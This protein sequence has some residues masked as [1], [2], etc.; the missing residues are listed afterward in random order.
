LIVLD[1]PCFKS[2][3]AF[4]EQDARDELGKVLAS[5]TFQPAQLQRRFLAFAVEELL[6]GRAHLLK[7][8]VIATEA[9][10][11][12]AS[13]DPR[14]D[15]I[16]RTEARKLRARLAKYYQTEGSREAFCIDLPK[17]SYVP[18][19]RGMAEKPAEPLP[20]ES[21][22][23]PP[24]E[25]LA[26][27]VPA[28]QGAAARRPLPWKFAYGLLAIFVLAAAGAVT[29][30]RVSSQTAPGTAATSDDASIAVLPLVNLSDGSEEFLSEGLTDEIIN[31]LTQIPGLRVVART[32]SFRFRA[33]AAGTKDIDRKLHVRA[34]LVG[35][36]R[37]SDRRLR[38]ALEL[39]DAANGYHLWSGNYETD[40]VGVGKLPLEIANAVTNA[41]GMASA[42]GE[43]GSPQTSALP[44]S[45]AQEDYLRGL[46]FQNK[47]TV[48]SLKQATEYYKRAIAEDPSFAQAYAGLADCYAL[49]RPVAATQPLEV[50]P[51]IRAAAGKAIELDDRLGEPH[52]D[53]AVSAE[54]EFDWATAE[55]EFKKGLELNPGNVLGHIWYAWYLSLTGREE[56][57]LTQRA[58]AVR[59]DPVSPYAVDAL[60]H[61]Y[62]SVGRFDT[63]VQQYRGSLALEPAF[64]LT[65]QDLGDAY[66]FEGNCGAAINEL[67]VANQ[68]MPGPRRMAHL[69]YAY[70]VCGHQAEAR[71][72]LC[73]FLARVQRGSVPSLAIAE[74]YLGLGDKDRAFPWLQKAIDERDLEV[75]LKGDPRFQLLR[76]D[77][78]FNT[79]LRRMKLG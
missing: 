14:L 24:P 13:F 2:P 41:L 65:H 73:Q 68:S 6:A 54:Y 59:L 74:I 51:K 56:Q 16:V 61:Y 66:L 58:I 32:S 62:F 55:S 48:D 44:N 45:D 9:L 11:R 29:L 35:S 49:G 19:F 20:A 26:V 37:K 47:F 25:P 33:N 34:V 70:G 57:V 52:I 7:E 79:L 63:A 30:N 71:Q 64:G 60:G 28:V 69:G 67:R 3:G 12:E 78:R 77:P 21:I 4:S 72:I 31:A 53:L 42:R 8:Y 76:S 38:V 27:T 46:Y 22:A 43:P 5:R 50:I 39:N 36:V 18:A 23:V 40:A 75:N 15:P 10:G 17:G 1:E